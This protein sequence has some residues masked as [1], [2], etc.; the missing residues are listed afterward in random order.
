MKTE[1]LKTAREFFN[2]YFEFFKDRLPKEKLMERVIASVNESC[3]MIGVTCTP[4]IWDEIMAEHKERETRV[5]DTYK[6]YANLL[7]T[8]VLLHIYGRYNN[9]ICMR[10]LEITPKTFEKKL[11][12]V[13]AEFNDEYNLDIKRKDIPFWHISNKPECFK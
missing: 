2:L 9:E 1:S 11:A 10:A 4:E 6:F 7:G 13:I 8:T 3:E 12:R 5:S